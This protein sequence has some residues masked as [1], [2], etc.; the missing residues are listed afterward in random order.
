MYRTD[1]P[2]ADYDRYC[3]EQEALWDELPKCAYCHEPIQ[4]D[5]CYEI[6]DELICEDC[7]NDNH[8]KRVD[9]YVE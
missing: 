2:A 8:R 3:A 5:Y 1:D 7:L 6:N 9:D 4:D